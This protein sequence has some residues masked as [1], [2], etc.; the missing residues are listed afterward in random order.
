MGGAWRS[1]PSDF[2]LTAALCKGIAT[3]GLWGSATARCLNRQAQRSSLAADHRGWPRE[4]AQRGLATIRP[5]LSRTLR[6]VGASVQQ[7]HAVGDG[8]TQ[9]LLVRI[10]GTFT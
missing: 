3:R 7:L 8:V 6:M 1:A 2:M 5:R 9:T 4:A 10:R